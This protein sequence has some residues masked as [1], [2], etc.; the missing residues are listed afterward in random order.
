M[1][2]VTN[3]NFMLGKSSL[4]LLSNNS[5]IGITIIIVVLSAFWFDFSG[6]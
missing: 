2:E 3:K 5:T 1:K 6:L 4:K